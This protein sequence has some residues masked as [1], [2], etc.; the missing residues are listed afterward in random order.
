MPFQKEEL[1]NMHRNELR[2]VT[3]YTGKDHKT[4]DFHGYFHAWST[5]AE[6]YE[7]GVGQYPVGIVEEKNSGDIRIAWAP[8]ITFTTV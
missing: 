8:L 7:S 4:E 6:E 2:E 3:V 5:D 1:N